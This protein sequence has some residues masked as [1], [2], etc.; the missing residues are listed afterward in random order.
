MANHAGEQTLRDAAPEVVF[1]RCGYFME[2]WAAALETIPKAGFFFTTLTP[3]DYKLSHVSSLLSSPLLSFSSPAQTQG[4]ILLHVC[5]V[6]LLSIFVKQIASQ[7]IGEAVA[8]ELLATGQGTP[9]QS[10]PYIFDLVGPRDYSSLD[11]HAAWEEAT[12]KKL[13]MRPVEKAG[14]AE[15]YATVFPPGVAERMA[16]LNLGILPGGVLAENSKP[17]GETKK[18]K[19]ELVEVF[20]QL[21]GN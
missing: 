17:T 13:E 1:V 11:V 7:D 4:I 2:N 14:L 18:G 15:F 5:K 8:T 21:L 3:L 10:S 19:T 9:V 6:S 12:G 16:E 20:K